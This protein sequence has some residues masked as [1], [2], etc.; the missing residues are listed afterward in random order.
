MFKVLFVILKF[1][2]FIRVLFFYRSNEPMRS[3]FG[4]TGSNRVF[5]ISKINQET[6]DNYINLKFDCQVTNK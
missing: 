6:A 2:C 1:V 5:Y 3:M 4:S